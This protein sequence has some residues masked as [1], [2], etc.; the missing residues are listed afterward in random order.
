VAFDRQHGNI[1]S[2]GYRIGV[3]TP[4]VYR[5]PSWVIAKPPLRRIDPS[6]WCST[7]RTISAFLFATSFDIQS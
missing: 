6:S 3:P 2:L 1:P 5:R 4:Y 7:H